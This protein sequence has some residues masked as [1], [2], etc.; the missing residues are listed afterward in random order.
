MH[1]FAISV[2]SI[3]NQKHHQESKDRGPRINDQLPGVAEMKC[4]AEESPNNNQGH[5]HAKCHGPPCRAGCGPSETFEAPPGLTHASDLAVSFHSKPPRV[6]FAP[7]G[8]APPLRISPRQAPV[9]VAIVFAIVSIKSISSKV[10]IFA[11]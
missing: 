7:G 4:R 5:G 2:L 1:G 3:L 11:G 8:R 6:P 10:C 9:S